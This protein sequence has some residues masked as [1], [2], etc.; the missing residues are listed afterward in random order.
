MKRVERFVPELGKVGVLGITDKQFGDIRLFFGQ[1]PHKPN[2]PGQQL[3][4]F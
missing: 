3:E 1:K 2:A 4:L